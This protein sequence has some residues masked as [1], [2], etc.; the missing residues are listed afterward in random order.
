MRTVLLT[1]IAFQQ[2]N[3]YTA[4]RELIAEIERGK[5]LIEGVE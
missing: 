3:F 1:R 5:R 2:G 4:Y